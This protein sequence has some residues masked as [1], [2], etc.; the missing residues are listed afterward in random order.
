M[1]V[2]TLL[3]ALQPLALF[4]ANPGPLQP[5]SLQPNIQAGQLVPTSQLGPVDT[6]PPHWP[7]NR[8]LLLQD[9]ASI[10]P[11]SFDE[12]AYHWQPPG[13]TSWRARLTPRNAHGHMPPDSVQ[14]LTNDYMEDPTLLRT[15]TNTSR[16]EYNTSQGSILLDS[17]ATPPFCV[18]NGKK[19]ESL[20]KVEM[21]RAQD[22]SYQH[23]GTFHWDPGFI[24]SSW[25]D[26]TTGTLSTI[27]HYLT[28]HWIA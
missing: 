2:S 1:C 5:E 19:R 12:S 14:L 22:L 8:S 28:P 13:P 7:A 3:A 11:H 17:V 21:P 27:V 20:A 9:E 25:S 4:S 10:P 24:N 18:C 15:Q 23:K 6:P 16:H 26:N